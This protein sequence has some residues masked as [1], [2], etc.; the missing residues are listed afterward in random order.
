MENFLETHSEPHGLRCDTRYPVM[1]VHGVGYRNK[2]LSNYWGRIPQAL[3]SEGAKLFY[4]GQSAWDTIENNARWIKNDILRVL[5]ETGAK[6]VN[7]IAHSK[8]GLDA[9]YMI[10]DLGMGPKVASLTTLS[11]PH[12]G[13][14]T[15][16]E[17][18]RLP[19]VIFKAAAVTVNTAF[20]LMGEKKPDFYNGCRQLSSIRCER[21]N[22][23]TPNV[24]GVFYQSYTSVI[25]CSLCNLLMILP[26]YVV[27]RVEGE[28]DGLVTVDSA[29]WGCFRGVITGDVRGISHVDIIDSKRCDNEGFD[30]RQFFIE[31]VEELKYMGF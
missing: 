27:R 6:K 22:R 4:S 10:H 20:R 17:L 16:D 15:I 13:S 9:R 28:N 7:L 19:P 25:H 18:R 21:F 29:K 5:R 8:G 1:F 24:P 2:S 12:R 23:K 30:S 14:K 26:N 3:E 31:L 11:T